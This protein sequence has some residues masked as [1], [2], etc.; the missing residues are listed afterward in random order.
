MKK[1]TDKKRD[2]EKRLLFKSETLR[3]LDLEAVT[4][5]DGAC[6]EPASCPLDSC[7]CTGTYDV[8]R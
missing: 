4:G 7:G 6:T 2:L 8:P 5:G 1:K 3:R